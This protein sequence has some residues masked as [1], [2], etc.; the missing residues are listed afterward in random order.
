MIGRCV[1][2]GREAANGACRPGD[3]DP[4]LHG[5]EG[6]ALGD[7]LEADRVP[8]LHAV[9]RVGEV[10][11]EDDRRGSGDAQDAPLPHP[12]GKKSRQSSNRIALCV[13]DNVRVKGGA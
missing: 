10:A 13:C 4:V 6:V 12:L 2:G 3:E 1:A 7:L 9:V 8:V 5:H 11:S